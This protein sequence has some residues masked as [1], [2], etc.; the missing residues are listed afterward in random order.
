MKGKKPFAT[1]DAKEWVR[2]NRLSERGKALYKRREETT[3]RFG[4]AKELHGLRYVRMRGL[5]N[6]AMPPY[7]RVPKHQ[8]MALLLSKRGKGFVIWLSHFIKFPL[9]VYI[10]EICNYWLFLTKRPRVCH[11]SR[12]LHMEGVFQCFSNLVSVFLLAGCQTQAISANRQRRRAN[13]DKFKSG[14]IDSISCLGDTK[15][16]SLLYR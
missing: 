14:M 5:A 8:K 3:E 15:I 7:C 1:F 10:S 13:W 4:D 2:Q 16:E 9:S 6:G 11:Q 12:P